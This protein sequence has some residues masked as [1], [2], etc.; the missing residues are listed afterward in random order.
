MKESLGPGRARGSGPAKESEGKWAELKR[1]KGLDE[2]SPKL[3][4]TKTI[5]TLLDPLSRLYKEEHAA[6]ERYMIFSLSSHT[7]THTWEKRDSGVVRGF[8]FGES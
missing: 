8:I 1:K 7:H 6:H 4:V 5:N 3:R 2:G